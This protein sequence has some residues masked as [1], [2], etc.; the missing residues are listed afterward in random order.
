MADGVQPR[1]QKKKNKKSIS[2]KASEFLSAEDHRFIGRFRPIIGQ[3][4]S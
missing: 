2:H 1:S 4:Q 3:S